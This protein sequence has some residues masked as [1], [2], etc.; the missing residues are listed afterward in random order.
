MSFGL[1]GL[2]VAHPTRKGSF[3]RGRLG[4]TLSVVF[5]LLAA[6]CSSAVAPP[7]IESLGLLIEADIQAG[8]TFEVSIPIDE[9]TTVSVENA[10]RGVTAALTPGANGSILLTVAVE[11]DTPR[12]AYNLGLIVVRDGE[13]YELVWP[14]DVEDPG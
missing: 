5:V 3:M 11:P 10:P 14:F 6:A 9:N 7:D 12:G 2:D 8:G 4:A 1:A 13:R